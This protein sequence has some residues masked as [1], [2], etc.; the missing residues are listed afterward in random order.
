MKKLL[1]IVLTGLLTIGTTAPAFALGPVDVE[2]ELPYYSKYVWRGMNTV[3]DSVLQP[4]I[5]LG[6]LGFKLAVWGNLDLTDINGTSGKFS[7][8]DYTLGYKFALPKIELGAGFIHYTFPE[9]DV[10]S[11]TEFYLSG[12]LGIFLS[13]SLAAYFD[14]DEVEGTY[15]EASVNHDFALGETSKLNLKGGLGLGSKSYIDGYFGANMAVP[16]NDLGASAADYYLRAS[17]PFHPIPL[18]SIVPSVTYTSLLGDAK[19]AVD[20]DGTLYS[21]KKENMIWGLA[22]SFSF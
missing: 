10:T 15:W 12:E 22:A 4:S 16:N 8:V 11:T 6:L 20:N 7:E 19:K 1:L 5:E 17:L 9:S 3:D 13:P 21:G 2:A 18:F 14:I